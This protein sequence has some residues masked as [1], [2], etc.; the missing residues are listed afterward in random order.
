MSNYACFTICQDNIKGWQTG[1]VLWAAIVNILMYSDVTTDDKCMGKSGGKKK[2][3]L[4]F[5]VGF[6]KSLPA[7]CLAS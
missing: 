6:A 1:D 7:D 4:Y 5:L 3:Q 2:G